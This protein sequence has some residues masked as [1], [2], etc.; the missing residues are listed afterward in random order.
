M[1]CQDQQKTP[2]EFFCGYD[3]SLI[4][5]KCLYLEDYASSLPTASDC[6][7]TPGFTACEKIF[8]E[9]HYFQ[10]HLYVDS[11]TPI[12]MRATTVTDTPGFMDR[13]MEWTM[14]PADVND[15]YLFR[16][17]GN[18]PRLQSVFQ[19]SLPG[20]EEVVYN[21]DE[22]AVYLRKDYSVQREDVEKSIFVHQ[23]GNFDPHF[24][25]VQGFYIERGSMSRLLN[26]QLPLFQEPGNI[27]VEWMLENDDILQNSIFHL[28]PHE[29]YPENS[30][31]ELPTSICFSLGEKM[32]VTFRNDHCLRFKIEDSY[33]FARTS[34]LLPLG[35]YRRLCRGGRGV[36]Q[37][38]KEK[39]DVNNIT[40]SDPVF[41]ATDDGRYFYDPFEFQVNGSR[42]VWKFE[43]TRGLALL[44]F[45]D[46]VSSGPGVSTHNIFFKCPVDIP[47]CLFNK[48]D[49]FEM[50][51]LNS[52]AAAHM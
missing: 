16:V 11:L 36:V 17:F 27:P 39:C 48:F 12:Y 42:V 52:D 31:Q 25:A 20:E 9:N 8:Q 26:P 28:L 15:R 5:P 14:I 24:C 10:L 4:I 51:F 2:L 38:Q 46:D 49:G 37:L 41:Q 40:I 7:A 1:L 19:I 50:H 43:G 23:G 29:G 22:D 33:V 32:R 13:Q 30:V 35:E 21:T 47:N 34:T 44:K 6:D 18:P 3:N 45:I